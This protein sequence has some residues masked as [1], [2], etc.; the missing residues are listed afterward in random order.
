MSKSAPHPSHP[1]L[2]PARQDTGRAARAWR[3][4]SARTIRRAERYRDLAWPRLAL[5]TLAGLAALIVS[6]LFA[7]AA[8]APFLLAISA[9]W[10]A[11]MARIAIIKGAD[12]LRRRSK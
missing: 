8:L 2:P 9:I 4:F 5:N 7:E 11:L 10:L 1:G 6:R 3:W 12:A